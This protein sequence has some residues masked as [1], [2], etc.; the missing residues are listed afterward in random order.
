VGREAWGIRRETTKV[1]KHIMAPHVSG[2]KKISVFV[3]FDDSVFSCVCDFH[4]SN[5]EQWCLL[6]SVTVR[7]HTMLTY[8]RTELSPSSEAANCAAIQKIPSN[9]KEPEGSSQEPSTGPYPEPVRSSP[10]HPIL[11]L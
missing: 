2:S 5:C 3:T 6:G 10:Y 9:F 1:S 7:L 11:S 4:S 8:L